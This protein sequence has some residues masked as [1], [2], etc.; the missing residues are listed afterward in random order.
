MDALAEVGHQIPERTH[1]PALVEAIEALRDAVVGRRDLVGI[2]RIQ[3]LAWNLRIPEDEGCAPQLVVPGR[4]GAAGLDGR[5]A[6]EP[7]SRLAARR[8][9]RV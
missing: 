7:G 9:N 8:L 3:L 2:D 1:L 4:R 5:L 6:R